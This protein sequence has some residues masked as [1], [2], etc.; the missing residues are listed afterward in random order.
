MIQHYYHH[1][2]FSLERDNDAFLSPLL[3]NIQHHHSDLVL[4]IE[5]TQNWQL[6]NLTEL[7]ADKAAT[8]A[9]C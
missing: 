6:N 1:L 8:K 7:D 3:I 9:S 4:L 2:L 5:Q